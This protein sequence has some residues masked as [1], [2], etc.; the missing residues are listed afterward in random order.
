MCPR[1]SLC[2]I[3]DSQKNW[4]YHTRRQIRI[5]LVLIG[6]ISLGLSNPNIPFVARYCLT[7]SG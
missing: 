3:A 4:E 2:V 7:G 6:S 5:A 1:V